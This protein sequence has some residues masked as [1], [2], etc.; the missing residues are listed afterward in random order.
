MLVKPR[1]AK[2]RCTA[3]PTRPRCPATKIFP[4]L[5]ERNDPVEESERCHRRRS[6]RG[7]GGEGERGKGRER[8]RENEMGFSYLNR[9][10]PLEK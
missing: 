1:E 2:R 10:N 9:E 7:R 3:D 8:E 6:E 4:D 5:S